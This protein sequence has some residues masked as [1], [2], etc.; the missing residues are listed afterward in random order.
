MATKTTTHSTMVE[1]RLDGTQPIYEQFMWEIKLYLQVAVM[2]HAWGITATCMG[3][4][5][6]Q[7][8]PNFQIRIKLNWE[9][10]RD[11]STMAMFFL[12]MGKVY[13]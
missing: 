8:W 2:P 11:Y 5:R 13:Y 9:T 3:H 6:H 7:L 4:N 10:D 1:T 12:F